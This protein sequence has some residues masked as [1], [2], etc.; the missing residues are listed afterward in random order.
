M[1][2][3]HSHELKYWAIVPAAGIGQ[4]MNTDTPKQYLKIKSKMLIEHTLE[5]LI[6]FPLFTKIIVVLNN[7]D[8]YAS[9]IN[10]LRH[11]KII[12]ATGGEKRYHSVINGLKALDSLADDNDWVMVHDAARPCIRQTDIEWLVECLRTHDVGGVIGSLVKNTIKRVDSNGTIVETIDRATLW[13]TFTPQMFKWK[14]LTQ[15]MTLSVANGVSITDEASAMEY[16]GYKP[17]MIKGYDD[18]IK[19]TSREDLALAEL[20]LEQQSKPTKSL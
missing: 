7:E 16:A 4:R 3:D 11:K 10:I 12:L 20:Y 5:R 9:D 17:M 19:V 18:N 14:A 1:R 6:Q 15:A 8:K 2:T 13:H